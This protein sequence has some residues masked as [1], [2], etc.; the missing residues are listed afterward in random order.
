MTG[1]LIAEEG[2]LAGL[3]LRFEAG[4]EWVLGRDPA[5]VGIVLE[6]PM[7]SRKHVTVRLTPEGYILENLS[8]VNPATQNGKIIS[9]PILLSEGDIIQIGNTFFRFTE[10]APTKSPSSPLYVEENPELSSLTITELPNTRWLLKV[11]T[12]P[13]S[14]AEFHMQKGASYILGKD[15]ALCDIV[16]QDLSVSRQHAKLSLDAEENVFIEDLGS[17]NGTLVNGVLI[18]DKRQLSSQDVIALGTTSFL[19]IDREQAMETIVSPPSPSLFR[20]EEAST[21]ASSEAPQNWKELVVPRR[22]LIFGGILCC[23]L[24]FSLIGLVS[25]FQTE[26]VI[27]HE[28]HEGER[29]Q[30]VVKSYPDLQYSYNEGSGK[31]FLIGHVLTGIEKQELIYQLKGL[32]FINTIEDSVVIDEYVWQN[33]NA[34]LAINPDWQGISIHS[35]APGKFILRGYVQTADQAQVLSDYLNLNFSYLDRLDNQVVIESNLMTQLQS[36]LLEKGFNNVTFQLSNG[37]LVLSGRVDGHDETRFEK[38]TKGFKGVAGIRS[39]KNYVIYTTEE[40]SLVDL[41]NKYRVMG[42]SKK[43]GENQ[44]IVINGRILSIGDVLDGMTVTAIQPMTVLLEKDGLKFKIN[45]N[46]Q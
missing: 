45:Y 12:G 40:S 19:T 36:E 23:I 18:T 9:E 1:F 24:L 33:M 14:G 10:Q 13:N 39:L 6:D 11:V 27:T 30:E 38:L 41:T 26:P 32:P 35:P 16:F 25:L 15:P 43:D 4:T 20:R 3:I 22:H 2:P 31:L 34:L 37:E 5:E 28:K 8:S 46:L 17:R 7:V 44:Y 42:Y 29:I 21:E